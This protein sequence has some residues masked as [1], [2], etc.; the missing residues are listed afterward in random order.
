MPLQKKITNLQNNITSKIEA[1]SGVAKSKGAALD[2]EIKQLNERIDDIKIAS[3]R[4]ISQRKE[5]Y[6]LKRQEIETARNARIIATTE[7]KEE[8]PL[9]RSEIAAI[10]EEIDANKKGKERR[11]L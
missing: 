10:Q 4:R 7:E 5:Q 9:L 2:A 3:D 8:I 1:Q 6:S 11:R